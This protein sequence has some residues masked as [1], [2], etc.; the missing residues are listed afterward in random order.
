[1]PKLPETLE[2]WY[3]SPNPKKGAK[4]ASSGLIWALFW[5]GGGI[6]GGTLEAHDGRM[7]LKE[8]PHPRSSTELKTYRGPTD[9]INMRILIIEY[10]M[11]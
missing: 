1:M 8:N 7:N 10:G 4:R 11:L 2:S 3:T 6:E 9:H 5:A